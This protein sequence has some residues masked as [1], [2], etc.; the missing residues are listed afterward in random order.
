MP[1]KIFKK[2]LRHKRDSEGAISRKARIK[3]RE[4]IIRERSRSLEVE[5]L[6]LK[7]SRENKIWGK[8]MRQVM[9]SEEGYKR[10]TTQQK[11][12]RGG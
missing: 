3:K 11:H 4:G 1:K 12:K 7:S 6:F 8:K 10:Q 9:L 5:T 2:L